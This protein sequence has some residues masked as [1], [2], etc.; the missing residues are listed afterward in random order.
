MAHQTAL[1][2]LQQQLDATKHAQCDSIVREIAAKTLE[3]LEALK[4]QMAVE[5]QRR[6]QAMVGDT[7]THCNTLQHSATLCN[8]LQ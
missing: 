8:T 6:V 5:R 7:A 3:Q 1:D 2:S 4:A